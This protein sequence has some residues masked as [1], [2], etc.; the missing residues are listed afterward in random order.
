MDSVAFRNATE[1]DRNEFLRLSLKMTG[2]HHARA[3]Y[4]DRLTCCLESYPEDR[5]AAMGDLRILDCTEV[6][7]AL[8]KRLG[9]ASARIHKECAE[10]HTQ[11]FVIAAVPLTAEM[12]YHDR[13]TSAIVDAV[14]AGGSECP[15]CDTPV[16]QSTHMDGRFLIFDLYA[17]N[18]RVADLPQMVGYNGVKYNFRGVV[19]G[20][21][22]EGSCSAATDIAH[23]IA[24]A[25][26]SANRPTEH[27]D[28]MKAVVEK[29]AL[30][31]L[32]NVNLAVFTI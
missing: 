21:P 29:K 30:R 18:L 32:H 16:R 4:K 14:W 19:R 31:T 7:T 28:D 20:V 11:D 22:G 10:G 8:V 25:F 23:Y 6:I 27:Y 12:L 5:V 1:T 3:L 26:R 15:R 2:S 9:L 13:V 24:T 17:T